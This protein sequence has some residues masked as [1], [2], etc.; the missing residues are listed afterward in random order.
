MS[1][2]D[3]LKNDLGTINVLR[4]AKEQG[5]SPGIVVGKRN[6]SGKAKRAGSMKRQPLSFSVRLVFGEVRYT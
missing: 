1:Y 4:F 5:I 2:D 6:R 3:F